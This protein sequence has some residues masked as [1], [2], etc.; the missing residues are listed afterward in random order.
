MR[1]AR[2]TAIGDDIEQVEAVEQNASLT[3]SSSAQQ[4]AIQMM[5]V[6]LKALSQRALIALSNLFTLL[7]ALSVFVLWFKAP[8]DPTLNQIVRLTLYAVFVLVLNLIKRR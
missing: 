5:M 2:L 6:A 8:T 3:Q 4:A 1:G 7:T